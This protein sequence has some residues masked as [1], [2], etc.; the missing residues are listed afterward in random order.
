MATVQV[1]STS[2]LSLSP[3]WVSGPT[4]SQ[5]EQQKIRWTGLLQCMKSCIAIWDTSFFTWLC[6]S[7]YILYS[8]K[9]TMSQFFRFEWDRR[10]LTQTHCVDSFLLKLWESSSFSPKTTTLKISMTDVRDTFGGTMEVLPCKS[11][12]YILSAF[13]KTGKAVDIQGLIEILLWMV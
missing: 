8:K 6:A 13:T 4:I 10:Q 9:K 2:C 1:Q 7:L 5:V 11:Y 12:T 3:S